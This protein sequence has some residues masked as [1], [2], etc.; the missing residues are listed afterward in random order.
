M[1]YP[2]RLTQKRTSV[3]PLSLPAQ[4]DQLVGLYDPFC[5]C[6]EFFSISYPT[7]RS[8]SCIDE[9]PAY[10]RG[11]ARDFTRPFWT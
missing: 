11:G 10:E 6:S 7:R 3:E 1:H 2:S 9:G 8:C 5:T 4:K